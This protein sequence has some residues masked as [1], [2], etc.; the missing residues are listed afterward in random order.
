MPFSAVPT[1]RSYDD[2]QKRTSTEYVRFDPKY[3]VVLRMLDPEAQQIWKHWIQAAN[4]GRGL[5]PVC[6][7]TEPGMTVCPVEK[8]YANLPKDDA[9]RKENNARRKFV[10]NVLDRTPYAT[11]PSCDSQTPAVANP[12]KPGSKQCIKCEA[13]IKTA[14]FKP[15]NKIKLLEQ[16]PRLFNE[17]LNVIDDMQ[18]ADFGKPITDYDIVFTTQGERRDKKIT[19]IPKEP[20]NLPDT[21]LLDPETGEPQKR[22]DLKALADPEST[23]IIQLMLEGATIDQLNAVRSGGAE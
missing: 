5:S 10:I 21:V 15:L 14:E 6:A 17:Q 8:Q 12:A 7:N 3:R 19:A 2:T 16:G 13:D 23:E 9:E 1:T 22:Y 11:C 4:G 20:E 18:M